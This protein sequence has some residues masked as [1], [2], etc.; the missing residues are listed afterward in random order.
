LSGRALHI[1]IRDWRRIDDIVELI[2]C[3]E[4][5]DFSLK[6][7]SLPWAVL[8]LGSFSEGITALLSR[9]GTR[10]PTAFADSFSERFY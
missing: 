3:C 5:R 2:L 1:P 8:I 4:D 10:V 6:P 7:H 9:R